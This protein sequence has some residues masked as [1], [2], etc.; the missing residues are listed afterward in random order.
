MGDDDNDDDDDGEFIQEIL[1]HLVNRVELLNFPTKV[2][3]QISNVLTYLVYYIFNSSNVMNSIYKLDKKVEILL[4]TYIKW[5]QSSRPIYCAIV[6]YLLTGELTMNALVNSYLF[7]LT[8]SKIIGKNSKKLGKELINNISTLINQS[9]KNNGI[10][11]GLKL[12]SILPHIRRSVCGKIPPDLMEE[13]VNFVLNYNGEFQKVYV[14]IA[15]YLLNYSGRKIALK[16]GNHNNNNNN[17]NNCNE[18]GSIYF[19]LLAHVIVNNVNELRRII[20]NNNDSVEILKSYIT[21]SPGKSF[22]D[23][24]KTYNSSFYKLRNM[25]KIRFFQIFLNRSDNNNNNNNNNSL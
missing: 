4:K 12:S 19:K 18:L 14:E 22:N 24:Y 7:I 2:G 25:E 10:S 15:I 8:P 13:F 11:L 1:E 6:H 3:F 5:F 21:L 16:K 20:N 17:N 23:H 9:E